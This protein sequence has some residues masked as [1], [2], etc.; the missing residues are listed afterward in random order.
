MIDTLDGSPVRQLTSYPPP[1][2][3]R[4]FGGGCWCW[5]ADG[6]A[7]VYAAV[8]GNLWLQPVP[9]GGVRQLTDHGPTR[10]AAGPA[11]V[12][13]AM[14]RRLRGRRGRG[15]GHATRRRFDGTTRRRHCRLR[16]RSV[17]D[18]GW[19][20]RGVAGVE[21]ARHAMG[22]LADP[23]SRLR[24]YEP[25]RAPTGRLHPT[26]AVHAR[27]RSRLAARRP[28]MA[29][30]V[31]RRRTAGRGAVR[32]RWPDVGNGP[33]VV[34]GLARRADGLRS[35]ATSVASVGCVWSMSVL[36]PSPKWPVVCTANCRGRAAGLRRCDQA[37]ERRL[38][39]WSTTTQRG[40]A[41]SLAI[42]PLSG[43][44]ARV[45][46]RARPGRDH[47]D[48]WMHAATPGCTAATHR[49]DRLLCW[50]H[51]GPSDQWQVTFMPRIAYWRAQGWNVLVPDHRGSTG[52]GRAYQQALRGRWGEL[53]VA[54]IVDA[55]THAHA[56]GLGLAGAHRDRRFIRRRVHRPRR[57]GRRPTAGCRG[58]R[59]LSGQ[60]SGGPRRAQPP[61]RAALHRVARRSTARRA[62]PVY[63]Q[64]SPV[65]FAERL[66]ATPLLVM[67][68]DSDPVV[69]VEQSRAF[70]ETCRRSRGR[71]RVRRLRRRGSRISQ[72]R[73]SARRV[74][75]HA[76]LSRHARSWRIA[77][78][79]VTDDWNPNDPDAT[80]VHYDLSDWSFEQMA[81]L[82]AALAD[83]VVPHAWDGNELIVPEVCRAG[84]RRHRRPGRD[85]AGHRRR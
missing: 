61:V 82:A 70:V 78:Q 6:D 76:G 79:L 14:S 51:G 22:F 5:S 9:A 30:P 40:S 69:P 33:A 35:P 7:V 71:S 11:A 77:S 47:R 62:Q 46:R 65:N 21:R 84:H 31:A 12:A 28:R 16:V 15:V 1:R 60:R 27:R 64:R 55:I 57:C 56:R 75:P 4:G 26:A 8:D 36:E 13:D 17:P 39:S 49:P 3:G 59:R 45:A 19:Q 72:A 24:R 85:A 10:A 52:H 43:W 73:Q 68:G 18:A 32:T 42:G 74:S 67:H 37:P 81:E 34:R 41:A 38:K 20:R 50:L 48:R 53:D 23:T 66:A 58:D 25:R 54:D 80:R 2:P 63:H 29:Q 44:E 83:A